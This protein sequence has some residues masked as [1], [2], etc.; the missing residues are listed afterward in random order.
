MLCLIVQYQ[1][2]YKSSN[3]YWTR[4][5]RS[6]LQFTKYQEYWLVR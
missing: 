5:S 4:N 2:R 3:A 6:G 1:T